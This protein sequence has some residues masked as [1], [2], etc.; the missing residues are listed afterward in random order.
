MA[1]VWSNISREAR[2]RRPQ[3]GSGAKISDSSL[4]SKSQENKGALQGKQAPYLSDPLNLGDYW[5]FIGIMNELTE[6]T[7][8]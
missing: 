7:L 2:D 6:H 8:P 3:T 5:L 1:L 4:C